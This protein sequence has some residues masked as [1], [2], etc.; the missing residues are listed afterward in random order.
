MLKIIETTDELKIIEDVANDKYHSLD[1]NEFDFMMAMLKTASDNTIER[2]R[3]KKT[4]NIRL[5]DIDIIGL[6]SMAVNDEPSQTYI[7]NM[8][9]KLTTDA[10]KV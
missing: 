2:L 1:S 4:I 8:I 6:K 9:H 10:L 3:K 5:L 7:S